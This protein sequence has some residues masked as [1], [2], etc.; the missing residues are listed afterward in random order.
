MRLQNVCCI[1]ITAIKEK[2]LNPQNIKGVRSKLGWYK[3]YEDDEKI[4]WQCD[5]CENHTEIV[6]KHD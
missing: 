4:V 3:A 2:C 5:I 1:A 6:Y